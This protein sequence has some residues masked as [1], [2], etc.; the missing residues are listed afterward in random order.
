MKH[1]IVG[2][3]GHI[4]HGKTALVRALTGIDTDRLKEEKERGISIDLGFAHLD[5]SPGVRL[6]FV[7]VPG[8]ERFI[9]NMLAGVAGIDVVLFI[10]AA[11]ESLKPQTLEHFDICRLLDIRRGIVV[12]TKADLVDADILELV[13]LEAEEFVKGSFLEGAPVVAVSSTT[14]AGLDELRAELARAAADAVEKDDTRWFRLP[15][16]RVFTMKGFGTVVTGTLISGS[17]KTEQ[18]VEVQPGGRTVRVRGIQ[19]HGRKVSSASA[20]QRTA[21][22]LS[23]I[24]PGDLAR[25]MMLTEPKRFEAVTHFDCSFELL[26]GAKSLRHRSPVHFHAGT[27]EVMAEIRRIGATAPFP[28]GTRQYARIKLVEPLLLLPGDR[29]IVRMFSPVV[30]IG[31]GAVID[32]APPRRETA[33]R[34]AALERASAGERVR[35]LVSE[36]RFGMGMPEL[37][38]RTG[39]LRTEIAAAARD[40]RL[41]H[42]EEPQF[43]LM[44][45]EWVDGK[46]ASLHEALKRFHRE[47][48]LLAGMSKE[49]LRARELADAP[50]FVLDALLRAAKTIVVKGDLVRLSSHTVALKEEEEEATRRIEKAFREAGLAAP[51]TGEVLSRSGVDPARSRTLLQ[52]LL[53]ERTLV[54]ISDDLVFHSSA[55]DRLH[56]ILA[57]RRGQRFAVPAFKD[58][59]GV[60]RKY[61]IPL[62]EFLDREHVTQREGDFR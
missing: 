9:K 50:P 34:L 22:N 2:T 7:D 61:A 10:I 62:L 30:T 55:I 54:R 36:S 21:L 39:M 13:R 24:E 26:P 20:G 51:S 52:I 14:G 58:W 3:A 27:A 49:D 17:V 11:D 44:D 47:K 6:G 59:T 19:T 28:P 38:A 42:L 41:V 8:H 4:D 53:R 29:F 46:I 15:I 56:A 40:P 43:W 31:G 23:G 18:D 25:G 57:E 12:L 1:V 45:K 48:P 35:L 5:L 37:I 16:D 60:S 32:I 33:E